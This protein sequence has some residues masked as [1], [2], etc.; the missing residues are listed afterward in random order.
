MKRARGVFRQRRSIASGENP[1]SA[2]RH[3]VRHN[4]SK[5][6]EREYD[7]ERDQAIALLRDL[8]GK[9]PCVGANILGSHVLFACQ[10]HGRRGCSENDGGDR[11][12]Q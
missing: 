3:E 6:S 2:W 1:V 9:L 10:G 4:I 5:L 8:D 11:K 12:Q 7:V